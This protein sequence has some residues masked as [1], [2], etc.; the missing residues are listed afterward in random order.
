MESKNIQSTF[1]KR[2]SIF[3][4]ITMFL[5][6]SILMI[7][8]SDNNEGETILDDEQLITAIETAAS[9]VSVAE[10]DLPPAAQSDLD[11]NFEYDAVYDVKYAD[12]LGYEVRLVGEEGTFTGEFNRAFYDEAGRSLE[13]RKRPR[14]GKRRSCFH[15][16]F[17]FTVTMPDGSSITLESRAD[18][19]LIRAWYES[20]PD[21]TEKPALVFP[22]DIEYQDGTVET[23]VDQAALIAAREGCKRVRCFDIVYPFSVTMPDASVITLNAKEDRYLIREWYKANPDAEGRPELVY[24]ID[25]EFED[26]SIQTINDDTEFEAAK[27]SCSE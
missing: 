24:P 27:E 12:N 14:F 4:M 22:V 8:C 6:S 3:L 18:K 19:S 20:N 5:L 1:L 15:L 13:D 17:P 10:E 21:A 2:S 9:R 11:L 26:G 7:S 16:V 23:I 25:I